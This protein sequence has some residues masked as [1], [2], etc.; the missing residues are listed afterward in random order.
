MIPF[1]LAL[2]GIC[3]LLIAVFYAGVPIEPHMIVATAPL[4]IL[5][6]IL[7]T[8]GVAGMKRPAWLTIPFALGMWGAA[9]GEVGGGHLGCALCAIGYG[10]IGIGLGILVES[11]RQ[12]NGR[13]AS[14]A[15]D[16]R[17]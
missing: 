2:F 9:G 4:G 15:V 16:R 17:C 8:K 10:L 3:F 5:V 13:E 7:A 12:R 6:L 1:S 11:R 14:P